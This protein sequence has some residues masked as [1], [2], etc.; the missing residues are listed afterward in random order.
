[1]NI[2]NNKLIHFIKK[3]NIETHSYLNSSNVVSF[4][5]QSLNDFYAKAIEFHKKVDYNN[6]DHI[7]EKLQNIFDESDFDVELLIKVLLNRSKI[8]G[9]KKKYNLRDQFLSKVIKIKSKL[10]ESKSLEYEKQA[11]YHKADTA[12]MENDKFKTIYFLKKI[13]NIVKKLNNPFAMASFYINFGRAEVGFKEID[14][15]KILY[16][17]ANKIINTYDLKQLITE[18]QKSYA[19][20]YAIKSD[21]ISAGKIYYDLIKAD[22]YKNMPYYQALLLAQYADTLQLSGKLSDSIEY[23]SKSLEIT[24]KHQNIEVYFQLH[25]VI[26]SNQAYSFEKQNKYNKSIEIYKNNLFT[27]QK[28][29]FK[30]QVLHNT[31]NLAVCLLNAGLY[32]E[33]NKYLKSLKLLLKNEKRDEFKYKEYFVEGG[34]AEYHHIYN[35]AEKNFILAIKTAN[36]SKIY[37]KEMYIKSRFRLCEFYIHVKKFDNALEIADKIYIETRKKVLHYFRF[38]AKLLK[39]KAKLLSTGNTKSYINYLKSLET[40]KNQL[41]EEGYYILEKEIQKFSSFLAP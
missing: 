37:S 3:L 5:L 38:Q 41:N 21:F 6:A 22:I 18:L 28:N 26:S 9:L 12:R 40:N 8:Y 25:L 2:R 11:Y 1:L 19:D 10:D 4:D 17:K 13:E 27:A 14:K 30:D 29:N 34:Y 31:S 7:Y 20:Y 36:K 32:E 15:A 23:Y 39:I 33:S 24:N 35:K 16:D